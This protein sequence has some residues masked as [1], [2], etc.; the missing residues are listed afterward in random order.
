MD[1]TPVR[2]AESGVGLDRDDT[3]PLDAPM[4][5]MTIR[6]FGWR[7]GEAEI[8]T[9]VFPSPQLGDPFRA[10]PAEAGEILDRLHARLR[11]EMAVAF[12]TFRRP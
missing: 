2:P 11:E 8:E 4:L 9:T 5:E 12:A 10:P 3:A 1:K 6:L 7:P